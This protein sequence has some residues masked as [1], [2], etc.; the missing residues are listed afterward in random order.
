MSNN[1]NFVVYEYKNVDVKRDTM[2]MY[3]ECMENFGWSLVENEGY[4]VQVLLSN[5]NPVNLGKNIAGAA[6]S[7]GE[8]GDSSESVTLTF[9]RDRRIENKQQ[10]DKLEKEYQEALA[11][12]KKVER[13]N[14]AQTMGI[15]LGTGIVG[16]ILIGL[17]IYCFVI[18]NIV[19]GVL[20]AVIGAVGW[21]FGFLSNR[22]MGQKKSTQ[23][24]PYIQEQL[25]IAYSTCEKAHALLA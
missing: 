13:K 6:Q 17:S 3:I 7:L 4:D 12:I 23:T 10:L 21:A 25:S 16:T 24:E 2:G 19:L 1:E 11:A 15:S 8:T 20:F 22:K 5:L 14:I 18:S 9:K